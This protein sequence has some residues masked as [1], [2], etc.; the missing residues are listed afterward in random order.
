MANVS[1]DSGEQYFRRSVAAPCWYM[2]SYSGL[3]YVS[4]TESHSNVPSYGDLQGFILGPLLFSLYLFSLGSLLRKNLSL[5]IPI[6]KSAKNMCQKD[7]VFENTKPALRIPLTV[8]FGRRALYVK[9]TVSD[10]GFK[11]QSN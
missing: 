3:V 10:L 5:S 7:A 2:W 1:E 9:P 8:D 4:Q 6:L 11:I